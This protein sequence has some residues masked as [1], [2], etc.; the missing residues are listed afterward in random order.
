VKTALQCKVSP[1]TRHGSR[2]CER[3]EATQAL[4]PLKKNEEGVFVLLI[5]GAIKPG[6]L[7]FARNDEIRG[8]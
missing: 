1:L 5:E 2:H 6:L 4:L 8:G 3:S 7:R